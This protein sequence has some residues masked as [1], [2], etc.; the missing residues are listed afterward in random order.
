MSKTR[1]RSDHLPAPIRRADPA[2]AKTEA[3]EV[4][5]EP[6]EGGS[7]SGP[8]S[9]LVLPAVQP[10]DLFGAL[11]ADARKPATRRARSQDV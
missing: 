10:L 6:A 1:A 5:V 2:H 3:L 4:I 11:L 8:G 9:A 7:G